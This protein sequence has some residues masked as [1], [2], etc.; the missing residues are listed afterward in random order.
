ML[1]VGFGWG[2][3]PVSLTPGG[4]FDPPRQEVTSRNKVITVV[5]LRLSA[6]HLSYQDCITDPNV[7]GFLFVSDRLT[8]V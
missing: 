4:N 6:F 1:M 5:R 3:D 8:V 7:Y 2:A